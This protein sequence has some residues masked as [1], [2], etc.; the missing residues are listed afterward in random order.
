MQH[1]LLIQQEHVCQR[2]LVALKVPHRLDRVLDY[3][4]GLSGGN[5]Q[6]RL[7]DAGE[8]LAAGRPARQEARE[9]FRRRLQVFGFKLGGEDAGQRADLAGDGVARTVVPVD[10]EF[11]AG[12]G[13]SLILSRMSP[14]TKTDSR[15]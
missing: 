13:T 7:H 6:E 11:F 15:K 3:L 5:V 14:P 4:R 2:L 8:R 1:L 12:S 10:Y 9:P